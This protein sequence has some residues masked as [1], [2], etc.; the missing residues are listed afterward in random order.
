MDVT[1]SEH[2]DHNNHEHEICP[3]IITGLQNNNEDRTN[4]LAYLQLI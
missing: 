4:V 1:R 3:R 2:S